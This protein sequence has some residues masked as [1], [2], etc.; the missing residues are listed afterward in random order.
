MAIILALVLLVVAGLPLAFAV[1]RDIVVAVVLAPMVTGLQCTAAAAAMAV[2]GGPDLDGAPFALWLSIV[3]AASW[4]LAALL[5]RRPRRPLP[6]LGVADLV[7]MYGPLLLPALLVRRP[8]VAWDARSIWWFH[9]AWIDAGAAAFRDA[10]GNPVFAYSH[11]D[12]PVFAPATIAGAWT[13]TSGSGLWVAQVVSSILTLSAAALFAYTVRHLVPSVSS[14]VARFVA[15]GA[16]L[17]VWAVAGYGVTAGYVDHLWAAA[18]AGAVVLLFIGGRVIAPRGVAGGEQAQTGTA[19]SLALATVLLAVAALTKNEGLVAAVIVAVVFTVR[20]RHRLRRAL[21]VWIPVAAGLAWSV[22]A[23]AFGATSD[24][25]SS[26]RITQLLEGDLEPLGRAG[27]TLSKLVGQTGW[28]VGAAVVISLIGVLALGQRR[29]ALGL[30]PVRWPW[31]VV[32]AYVVA[33][34]AT[35][36]V[37]PYAI[38]WHLATSID[39]VSVLVVLTATAIVSSWVLVAVAPDPDRTADAT[40]RPRAATRPRRSPVDALR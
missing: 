29:R 28:F 12:Y 6:S 20:S 13:V 18:L 36:V 25:S 2:M 26:P 3:T 21:W 1:T 24:L 14:M 5:V 4:G 30:A 22:V 16:G 8:P 31:A 17:S 23:R 38:E 9:A 35:Y 7:V 33:I 19:S 39:R 15:L 27:P 10:L 37:S 34:V 40:A 11:P 32:A